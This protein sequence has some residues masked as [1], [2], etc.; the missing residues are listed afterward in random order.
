MP[1][2]KFAFADPQ[3]AVI[4]SPQQVLF[5]SG[6]AEQD[7]EQLAAVSF[8]SIDQIETICRSGPEVTIVQL[9]RDAGQP[10]ELRAWRPVHSRFEVFYAIGDDGGITICDTMRNAI[11]CTPIERRSV[12]REAM[13]DHLIF[14]RIPMGGSLVKG[15][16]RIAPGE[17]IRIGIGERK[18]ETANFDFV[19]GGIVN[20]P[21]QERLAQLDHIFDD[22]MRP[23]RNEQGLFSLF[24]GGVDSTLLYTYLD[25][26]VPA[27]TAMPETLPPFEKE[28]LDTA[29]SLLGIDLQLLPHTSADFLSEL[30]SAIEDFGLPPELDQIAFYTQLYKTDAPSFVS[31][32]VADSL[33]GVYPAEGWTG[34]L[35]MAMIRFGGAD[36]VR[37]L[38]P[39]APVRYRAQLFEAA[40][41]ADEFRRGLFDLDGATALEDAFTNYR[42]LNLAFGQDEIDAR[43]RLR[44]DSILALVERAAPE[45]DLYFQ[46]LEL[47]HWIGY[48]AGGVALQERQ[49]AF[50]YGKTV[51]HP[52]SDRRLVDFITSVPVRDRYLAPNRHAKPWLKELILRRLPGYPAYCRKGTTQYPMP[53]F[54]AP[55]GPLATVWEKYELPDPLNGRARDEFHRSWSDLDWNALGFAIW[56]NRVLNNGALAITPHTKTYTYVLQDAVAPVYDLAAP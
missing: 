21:A 37:R 12:P 17:K 38:T 15:W 55:K 52:F 41:Q 30:E 2:V 19:S 49:H 4:E 8:A 16:C 23:L 5:V 27:V 31:G 28:T 34:A 25:R 1:Q 18:A 46:H 11:A 42:I 29:A 47:I 36:L 26:T 43:L 32:S 45:N 35:M 9:L 50:A 39:L 44:L 3:I 7:L 51:F 33:F 10:F 40:H 53:D 6:G 22:I 24:S 56:R 48:I 20:L 13:L 54:F 14:R